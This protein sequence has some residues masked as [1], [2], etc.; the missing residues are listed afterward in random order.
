MLSY[1][2]LFAA[3]RRNWG[4]A[5]RV[6]RLFEAKEAPSF[7]VKQARRKGYSLFMCDYLDFFQ[8][9]QRGLE[10]APA[11]GDGEAGVH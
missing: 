6:R 11:A 4:G 2:S 7:K 9:D 10:V 3:L 5:G 1:K 8:V